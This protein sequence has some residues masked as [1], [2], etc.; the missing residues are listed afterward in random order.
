[1]DSAVPRLPDLEF[2]ERYGFQVLPDGVHRC[3]EDDLKKRFVTDFPA[4]TTRGV[5]CDGFLR[6]RRDAQTQGIHAIQWIDGSFVESVLDPE[7][8]DVVSFCDYDSLNGLAPES[9][10][11]VASK[12]NAEESTKEEYC[13]H[14]FLVPSCRPD[15]PYYDVFEKSRRYWR[16]WFG[17][18]NP[19]RGPMV[20][21]GMLEMVLGDESL[22]TPV[23]TRRADL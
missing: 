10:H 11:F 5:I 3:G 9:L 6:L 8:A 13:T 1:M 21:K 12:L 18:T 17:Q 2:R 23:D 7:D 4:S 20:P 16:R 15:H 19:K 22:T 14:T